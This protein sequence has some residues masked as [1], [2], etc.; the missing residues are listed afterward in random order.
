MAACCSGVRL[1]P[2]EPMLP[3]LGIGEGPLP[4]AKS[5]PTTA[6]ARTGSDKG[7]R[8]ERRE[9]GSFGLEF[10]G[11]PASARRPRTLRPRARARS[12]ARR[13]PPGKYSVPQGTTNPEKETGRPLDL[14]GRPGVRRERGV[15]VLRLVRGV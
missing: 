9:V 2:V 1:G 11:P 13:G 7:R 3:P 8:K 5:G 12:L 15:S 14:G 4:E 10:T 6:R